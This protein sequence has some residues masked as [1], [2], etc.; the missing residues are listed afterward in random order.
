ARC[1]F[2]GRQPLCGTGV[3]SR[4]TVR[5]RPIACKARTADSRPAPDPFT[6]TSTYFSPWPI[7][8]RDASCATICAAYAVLLREPLNPTLPAL[9]QPIT[10]P[11]LSV[12]VTIVLL[13][14]ES[15]CALPE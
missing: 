9:D 2:G 5:S 8:C 12:I 10:L 4:I 3:T 6:R 15:S 14:V 7:A 1:C 11:L 13:Y